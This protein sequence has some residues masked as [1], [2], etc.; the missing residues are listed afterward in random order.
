MGAASSISNQTTNNVYISYDNITQYNYLQTICPY[1]EQMGFNVIT[2]SDLLDKSDI[3][4]IETISNHVL[5]FLAYVPQSL[6]V[7]TVPFFLLF[8]EIVSQVNYLNC[9]YG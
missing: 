6:F 9:V 2:S 4:S 3:T 8:R 7:L 1:I 5:I